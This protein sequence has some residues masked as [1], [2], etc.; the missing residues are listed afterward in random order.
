M[1]C[2]ASTTTAAWR[3]NSKRHGNTVQLHIQGR[4]ASALETEQA[5][6]PFHGCVNGWAQLLSCDGWLLNRPD[7]HRCDYAL[8]L[9]NIDRLG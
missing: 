9:R 7:H 6:G 8:G 2:A 1:P 3:R 5:R 4:P